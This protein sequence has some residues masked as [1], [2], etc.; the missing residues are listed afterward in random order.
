MRTHITPP[1]N[2]ADSLEF[3]ISTLSL[4]AQKIYAIKKEVE[5]NKAIATGSQPGIFSF[6]I[7][8]PDQSL[9]IVPL[10]IFNIYN[11]ILSVRDDYVRNVDIARGLLKS[12]REICEEAV[13][14]PIG[15][16]NQEI[17]QFYQ[18]ASISDIPILPFCDAEKLSLR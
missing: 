15:S 8:L 7:R 17:I 13:R 3:S 1:Y 18:K 2:A 4:E 14:N 16:F 9:K 10:P 11:Y 12:I 6:K 5:N